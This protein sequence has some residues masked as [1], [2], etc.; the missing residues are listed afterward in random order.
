MRQDLNAPWEDFATSVAK[1][2]VKSLILFSL[3]DDA[4]VEKDF[5]VVS[6]RRWSRS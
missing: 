3:P 4:T 6:A 5:G 1:V 2:K